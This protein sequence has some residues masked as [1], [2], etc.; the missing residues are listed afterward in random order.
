VNIRV[1]ATPREWTEEDVRGGV[2]IVIDVLRASSTITQAM[3]NGAREVVPVST[4]AEAGELAVKAGRADVVLGG[5]RD[6]KLIE[7]F[8]LGNS[9]F[10]YS[11]DRVNGRTVIFASTNG[12]PALVR[13]KSAELVTIGCFNNFSS[14]TSSA[15]ESGLDVSIICSGR[16]GKFS[17]EDFVCA[18]KIVEGLTASSNSISNDGAQ[19]SLDLFRYYRSQ[20]PEVVRN[21]YHGKYLASLGFE[22]DLD[23]CAKVDIHHVV[24]TLIEGKIRLP[25][26]NGGS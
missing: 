20:I 24:P 4:P 3:V 22:A 16:N 17:L 21:S 7:G 23:H 6:G 14:V 18:G 10:E 26:T 5:E 1:F 8:D 13:A 2:A 15:R 19:G 12:S 11:S 25:K 9:P